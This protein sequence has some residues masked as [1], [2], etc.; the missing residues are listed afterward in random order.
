MLLTVDELQNS[1]P[2]PAK[3]AIISDTRRLTA[4][5]LRVPMRERFAQQMDQLEENHEDLL[6][7]FEEADKHLQ[8]SF[9][10]RWGAQSTLNRQDRALNAPL[11]PEDDSS[12][13][14]ELKR[15]DGWYSADFEGVKTKKRARKLKKTKQPTPKAQYN[16]DITE[17]PPGTPGIW[18]QEPT[19]VGL[20]EFGRG[21]ALNA[22]R[23]VPKEFLTTDDA[24]EFKL[25]AAAKSL[26]KPAGQVGTRQT[27]FYPN[28]NALYISRQKELQEQRLE[29][30]DEMELDEE[31]QEGQEEQEEEDSELD[32]ELDSDNVEV[33]SEDEA[34]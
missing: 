29:G 1:Q 18:A 27:G 25:S 7:A 15:K 32:S 22:L 24:R 33:G 6:E 14:D 19:A 10:F 3:N 13:H 30:E 9:G 28:A 34:E 11:D 5:G 8:D 16:M 31:E 17:L 4:E 20:V 23:S 2:Y 26:L 21:A 12:E